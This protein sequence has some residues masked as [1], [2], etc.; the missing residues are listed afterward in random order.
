MK[1]TE[2]IED[3]EN[4]KRLIL[5]ENLSFDD[6][7]EQMIDLCKSKL[8]LLR[9]HILISDFDDLQREINFYK[10]EK[11]ILVSELYFYCNMSDFYLRFHKIG[12]K[13]KKKLIRKYLIKC[14]DFICKN[15]EIVKYYEGGSDLMDEVYF[16]RKSS[17]EL[18]SKREVINI[19]VNEDFNCYYSFGTFWCTTFCD[20]KTSDFKI[21][22]TLYHIKFCP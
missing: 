18:V 5:S 2:I 16:T 20:I 22:L 6:L 9:K 19:L 11:P 15:L 7:S 3:F 4:S 8:N 12:K 17:S 13:S 14:E 10:H 1:I 21:V